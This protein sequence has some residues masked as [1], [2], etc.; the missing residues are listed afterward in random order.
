M[1]VIRKRLL[2]LPLLLSLL[3]VP[4]SAS[5]DF[6]AGLAAYNRRDFKTA[7]KEFRRL[8]LKGLAKAQYNLGVMYF[9]GQGVPQDYAKAVEWYRKAADQGHADS[10]YNLGLMYYKG[11]GVPQDYVQAHMWFNLA[12]SR[13]TGEKHKDYSNARDRVA[14]R[15]SSRQVSEAQRLAREWK[16]KKE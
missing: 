8:A 2:F 14:K 11:Q 9:R 13:V 7:L 4:T 1:G 15:M 6:A 3:L 10:Q 12:A 16:P 5:A